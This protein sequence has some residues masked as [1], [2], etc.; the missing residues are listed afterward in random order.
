M[1]MHPYPTAQKALD[2]TA[3]DRVAA[4]HLIRAHIMANAE[5]LVAQAGCSIKCKSD[6]HSD[7]NYGC[8]NDGSGCICYCHDQP[9]TS[10]T[11]QETTNG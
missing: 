5:R 4:R 6:R 7:Q 2:L 3:G 8:Q 10:Y 11:E 9:A 1:S